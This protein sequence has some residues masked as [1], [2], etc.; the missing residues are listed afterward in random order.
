MSPNT[1][2]SIPSLLE[3]DQRRCPTSSRTQFSR[4]PAS[5]PS[6]CDGRTVANVLVVAFLM[7]RLVGDNAVDAFSPV[8]PKSSVRATASLAKGKS[9][10]VRLSLGRED[11]PGVTS[12]LFVPPIPTQSDRLPS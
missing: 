11:L 8:S 10:R 6:G 1:N 5:E 3:S 4:I 2:D 9:C 7:L 12:E